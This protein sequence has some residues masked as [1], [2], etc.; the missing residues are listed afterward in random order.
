MDS[1]FAFDIDGFVW[2]DEFAGEE[3]SGRCGDYVSD[4]FGIGSLAFVTAA[5]SLW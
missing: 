1:G 2:R 5:A 3:G 4:F